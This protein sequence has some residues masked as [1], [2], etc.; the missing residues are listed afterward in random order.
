MFACCNEG[1]ATLLHSEGP[2]FGVPSAFG[3]LARARLRPMGCKA[4]LCEGTDLNTQTR[5][6]AK[7]AFE[8]LAWCGLPLAVIATIAALALTVSTL[9]RPRQLHVA[10]EQVLTKSSVGQRET[11][12]RQDNAE[13]EGNAAFVEHRQIASG[14]DA[15]PVFAASPSTRR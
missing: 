1:A 13:R 2:A 5:E 12:A 4:G 3:I 6:R 8:R 14:D 11:V 7:N 10:I 9:A 15:R